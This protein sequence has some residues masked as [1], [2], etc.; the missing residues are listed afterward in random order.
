MLR[1]D[2]YEWKRAYK[3]G[4]PLVK[5]PGPKPQS[6]VQS[7]S[8]LKRARQRMAELERKIGQQALELDFF[9]KAL[10]CV[11]EAKASSNAKRSV[12]SYERRR[13]KAN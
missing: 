9:A 6:H 7:V 11:E 2:L 1:K 4:Q 5:R 13:R 10:R 3:S 12:N 8:E